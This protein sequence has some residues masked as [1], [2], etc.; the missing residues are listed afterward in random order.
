MASTLRVVTFNVR[1]L[2]HPMKRKRVMT[3]LKKE[4]VEIA[5][6]Q[7]THLSSGEHKKLKRD[8]VGQIYYSNFKH[9]KRGVAILI[10]KN[11]PFIYKSQQDD[12]EG[13]YILI[14][15]TIYGHQITILNV[16]APNEDRPQFMIDM[17]TL[18][19]QFNSKLGFIGGD[20]NCCMD[21]NVDKSSS[22]LGNPKASRALKQ[23]SAQT[24]LTDVWRHLNPT[25]RDYTFYSARHGTYSRLDYFFLPQNVLSSVTSCNIGPI[26]I[27]DHSP[28]FL[29]LSIEQH[30]H[31]IKHW[32]FN[33]SLLS[34]SDACDN[35][36]RWIQ[37]YTEDNTNTPVSSAIIWDAAKAVI[38][39]HLIS[40]TTAK[41]RMRNKSV[42]E[43][44]RQLQDTERKHKQHPT[45]DNLKALNKV[46]MK[47]NQ[48]QTENIQKLLTFTRQ[49]Y[50]EHGNKPNR[51]LAYQLKKEQV[52]R[53]IK[54]IRATNGKIIY[55]SDSIK[56]NFL[57][58]YK[59][60]Y[61]TQ[62][63]QE[64]DIKT[65]LD[66]ISLP[67]ISNFDKECLNAPFT[68]DE[69]LETIRSLPSGKSPGLDGY[70]T[71]FYKAF[72][73][74]LRPLFM[75]MLKDFYEKGELPPSMKRAL[76]TLI[77]KE[78]K[79]PLDCASYRPISLL[80]VDFKIISKLIARR[81]ESLMPKLINPDQSGFTK[82]R[83]ASDNIRR[84]INIIDHSTLSKQQ[85]VILSLDAEKAFDRVEWPYLIQVLQKFN[86]GDNC[87]KWIKSL[88]NDPQAIIAINGTF[89]NNFSLTRGCRQGCPLSPFLFNL[90]IEPLAETIR[91]NKEI[92]GIKIKRLDNR[93]SLYADD[94]L[95]YLTE[96]NKSIPP[97]L[98][99]LKRFG[100]VSGYKVNLQK[101]GAMMLN[102][103]MTKELKELSPFEWVPTGF[104]YLGVNI[105]PNL[106]DLFQINYMP[107]LDRIK[108]EMEHW[109]L[110]PLSLLGRIS[111]IKMNI[112]PRFM[113][114]YQSLPSYVDKKFFQTLNKYL[115]KFI[116]KK[117]SPRIALK[118]L[119]KP[120]EKGGLE[121]PDFQQYY[122][123][124]QA[125]A[126]L[127]WQNT[128]DAPHWTYI[129]RE[130]CNPVMISSLPFINNVKM[131]HLISDKYV[132]YNILCAW[133]EAKKHC[134]LLTSISMNAPLTL[135]PDLPNTVGNSLLE[136]WK[137]LGVV[138]FKQLFNHNIL[139]EFSSL[140]AE[141]GLPKQD[142]FKYL[143][144]R[145]LITKLEKQ[146]Q[147]AKEGSELEDIVLNLRPSKGAISKIYKCLSEYQDSCFNT[148]RTSWQ[149][150]LNMGISDQQWDIICK[151]TFLGMSCNKVTEQ[152]YKF[153]HRV[154]ITP[155]RLNRM[156]PNLS[157]KCS[158]CKTQVGTMLH[159]FW[160]CKQ[161]TGFWDLV[162]GLMV[163]Q[164]KSP[165][166][167]SPIICL[168]GTDLDERQ[169]SVRQR[170]LTIMSYIAKKCILL[171][172]N[173]EKPP[174]FI[175]FKQI[176]QDTLRLEY[177]TYSL[178]NRL[179]IFS[180]MWGNPAN[181]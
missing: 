15:G 145:H 134:G 38:R 156:F 77:Y 177:Q 65:F 68:A 153:M 94:I 128:Q 10:H 138:Q 16:Y 125:K 166:D 140:K 86:L 73:P 164:T 11:L 5:L 29:N 19:T 148:L 110:L 28:V 101:T 102:S 159:M 81:L 120:K 106:N 22:G 37:Q 147:L 33:S 89:T 146:N 6:L 149:K 107:L 179:D 98:E 137:S 25:Q 99:N 152:N 121:L 169:N 56:E 123:S 87:I 111:T 52:E 3:F 141:F 30:R 131:I 178:K 162:H 172:W 63:P 34:C 85:V 21:Y 79:D 69:V 41:N 171:H 163:E 90:V 42:E 57:H 132:V 165:L 74:Q 150:D 43:L 76:I 1:G 124:C 32:K 144:L 20:F 112:L 62:N 114:L 96:P 92:S 161:L 173:Q 9:N 72:W 130:R 7:E 71:E 2:W 155:Q 154:Y 108:E 180:D 55:D 70:T 116:W 48:I 176:L 168:F 82:G 44:Q 46:K 24:A 91:T 31:Q 136:T 135:N 109:N 160:E 12:P 39:G 26:L 157:S 143:Q 175:M 35:I 27:S 4:K 17:I 58:F 133:Q 118:T 119:T 139:K 49:R 50:Y 54:G 61:S 64:L 129:E 127:G 45:N 47:I 170:Q 88:Y 167:R 103:E 36:K 83:Y 181:L 78:G 84:L 8:W 51:L 117:A 13:R 100:S 142:F 151:N 113:Y 60:L 14:S 105:T 122:W 59:Q 75:P 104:K 97:L 40:Y 115:T 53:T 18:Y 67:T 23:M 174:T 126:M 158:R 93:I 66:K 95:I 80:P